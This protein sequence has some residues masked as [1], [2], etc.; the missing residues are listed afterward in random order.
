VGVVEPAA[1]RPS[2]RLRA[3][4][5]HLGPLHEAVVRLHTIE[6]LR[7]RLQPKAPDLL[8]LPYLIGDDSE[9]DEESPL[10]C[11]S[12]TIGPH[13]LLLKVGVP[14]PARPV[15]RPDADTIRPGV[16]VENPPRD[17]RPPS[18]IE[19]QSP[20]VISFPAG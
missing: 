7:Q 18:L 1:L 16:T 2:S 3:M 14:G 13:L 9:Q 8:D 11:L 15:R 6:V 12:E 19:G 20:C 5:A 4:I 10:L 17:G